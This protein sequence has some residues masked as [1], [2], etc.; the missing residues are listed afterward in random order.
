MTTTRPNWRH[1]LS[2]SWMAAID[3]EH[4]DAQPELGAVR[5]PDPDPTKNDSSRRSSVTGITT[6]TGI[7]GPLA[8]VRTVG[9]T[10]S[11]DPRARAAHVVPVG[12]LRHRRTCARA[13]AAR[14]APLRLRWERSPSLAGLRLRKPR[15]SMPNPRSRAAIRS[16]LEQSRHPQERS[17]R[18]PSRSPTISAQ[19]PTA[20]TT[21]FGA[22]RM[23]T[24][25]RLDKDREGMS[26]CTP[27]AHSCQARDCPTIPGP[28]VHLR[29][30]PT[31][32]E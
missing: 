12:L 2:M 20:G 4:D 16:S 27:T 17:Y 1:S 6:K 15:R 18:V 22:S 29:S 8:S 31:V 32:C 21:D 23:S 28:S 5:P 7:S 11:H 25:R 3:V 19:G 9:P 26:T 10:T 30:I 24:A 13:L 14:P